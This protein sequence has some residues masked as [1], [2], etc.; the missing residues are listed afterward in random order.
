MLF[1][2]LVLRRLYNL[3]YEDTER[4]LLVNLAYMRFAGINLG[5]RVPD[6]TTIRLFAEKLTEAELIGP[7]FEHFGALLQQAGLIAREDSMVDATFVEAE[8]KPHAPEENR[9]IREG[10]MPEG[11]D[12]PAPRARH[13]LSQKDRDARWARKG[14]VTYYGYKNTVKADT[15]SKLITAWQVTDAAVHDLRSLDAVL[16]DGDGTVLC[17]AGYIGWQGHVTHRA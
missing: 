17:D 8:R 7:L 9:A 3:S 11:W 12:D 15:A 4:N 10:R 16:R 1:K 13:K 14:G 2:L 5:D 6:A